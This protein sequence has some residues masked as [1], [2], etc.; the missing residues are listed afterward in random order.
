[1]SET[2]EPVADASAS[3]APIVGAA[4]D[5]G[6]MRTAN[7][8]GYLALEPVYVVVDGMGGHSSGRL[9]ARTALE[10]ISALAGSVI[11]DAAQVI[12]AIEEAG[13]EVDALPSSGS[14]RPGATIAGIALLHLDGVPAWLVFNLGDA[15]VY[16]LRDGELHQ[17]TTD[18]SK[19]QELIES[20]ELS[21]AE[22]RD[23]F[24]KNIVTRALGGGLAG[25]FTPSARLLP[26]TGGERFLVCS[27]G[28]SDEL[29]DDELALIL[30]AGLTPQRTAEAL[31]AAALE[32]GG[33]DNATAMVVDLVERP[34]MVGVVTAP[35]R[36]GGGALDGPG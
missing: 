34:S 12:E 5:V 31:V 21:R 18:H 7:E 27:D 14:H 13:E 29:D 33:H 26:A 15:R 32:N 28:L 22:A 23:D 11:S 30:G 8:D 19:V 16:L 24:R 3:Q 36:S 20:G 35:E 4:T 1:M 10:R 9:A 17:V 25:P 2:T 6:R